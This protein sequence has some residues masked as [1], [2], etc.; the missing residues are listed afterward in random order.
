VGRYIFA[1]NVVCD[2][3][4][5]QSLLKPVVYV[6]HKASIPRKLLSLTYS[7]AQRKA[8]GFQTVRSNLPVG[9]FLVAPCWFFVR[10]CPILTFQYFNRLTPFTAG[11]LDPSLHDRKYNTVF[12]FRDNLELAGMGGFCCLFLQR[13]LREKKIGIL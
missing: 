11:F 8:W 9:G 6:G 5:F 3:L 10:R 2:W 7:P 12:A 13:S 1:G 4:Y